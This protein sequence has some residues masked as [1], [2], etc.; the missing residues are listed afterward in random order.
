M[1]HP[2]L[3]YQTLPGIPGEYFRCDKLAAEFTTDSC[4][5]R[6]QGQQTRD[7]IGM[8]CYRCPI[9]A[10]HA[11]KA[12]DHDQ[13]RK[14]ECVR[15]HQH[16]HK[17]VRGLICV[18]CYNRQQEV[19][20]GQDRRGNPPKAYERLGQVEPAPKK[21]VR[22]HLFEIR[23]IPLGTEEVKTYRHQGADRQEAMLA[24][25]R[26]HAKPPVFVSVAPVESGQDLFGGFH[27]FTRGSRA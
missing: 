1:Q 15:C 22:I 7:H 21:L 26:Q 2:G 16:S 10:S 6:W 11:N 20:K 23:Y 12:V 17:L 3:S 9:G 25:L 14:F 24:V 19:L 13:Y 18:S 5:K 8:P 4:A 27:R